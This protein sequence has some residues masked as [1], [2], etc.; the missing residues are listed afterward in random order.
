MET[1][2]KAAAVLA[3]EQ[4]VEQPILFLDKGLDLFLAIQHHACGDGLNAACGESGSYLAPEQRRELVAHNAIQDAASL[5]RVYQ[6]EVDTARM[7]DA[8]G[9]DLLGDFIEGYAA[10]L[11][12]GQTKQLLEVPGNG[13]PFAVRVS[14]KIDGSGILGVLFQLVDQLGLV[15]HGN[16]LRLKAVFD[17][18]AHLALGQ[19]AQMPHGRFHFIAA[20]EVFFY[21]LGLGR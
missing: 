19:V 15:P 18:D 17:I 14:R 16:I 10:C 1:G 9:D 20:A 4:R 8:L 2:G 11:F 6:V 13:L 5:L 3:S 7:L 12:I 21:R